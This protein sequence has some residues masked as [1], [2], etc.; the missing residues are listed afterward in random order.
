MTLRFAALL[1]GLL[2]AVVPGAEAHVRWFVAGREI[3]EVSFALD[4]L[5]LLTLA[6]AFGFVLITWLLHRLPAASTWGRRLQREIAVPWHIDWYGLVLLL[7]LLL[8]LNLMMG[9]FLAPNL[10]LSPQWMLIGVVIQVTAILAS[11]LSIAITGVALVLVGLLLPL[12]FGMATGF[13]YLFEV[14]GVGLAYLCIAPSLS[15][16]DRR[17]YGRVE[18]L[19]RLDPV[20][21][22]RYAVVVLRIALGLQ[23]MTLAIHNKLSQPGATLLFLQDFPFYNFMQQLGFESYSHLHFVLAAGLFELVFG[24]MLVLGWAPRF[25]LLCLSAIFATTATLNGLSEVLG[26][27]PIFAVVAILLFAAHPTRRDRKL[28][29]DDASLSATG[30][31]A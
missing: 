17:L 8:V 21:L 14:C 18:V 7:N 27:L 1:A 31:A 30:A 23:L 4:G 15:Q 9:D 2:L 11:T 16:F 28:D 5:N 20:V 29:A 26:H 24:A 13:D 22:K 19:R 12:V 25:V 10:V 6:G 3:P